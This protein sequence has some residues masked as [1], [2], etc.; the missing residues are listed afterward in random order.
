MAFQKGK[1]MFL[2]SG[3]WRRDEP[4]VWLDSETWPRDLAGETIDLLDL[5]VYLYSSLSLLS[6]MNTAQSIL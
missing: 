1:K 6:S 3:V 5:L 2:G 4:G